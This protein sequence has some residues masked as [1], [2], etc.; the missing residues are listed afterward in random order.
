M[1]LKLNKPMKLMIQQM[2]VA[3]TAKE[4]KLFL[5]LCSSHKFK[6]LPGMMNQDDVNVV[7]DDEQKTNRNLE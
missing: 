7:I 3:V 6:T 4:T 1:Q 5:Q 2:P